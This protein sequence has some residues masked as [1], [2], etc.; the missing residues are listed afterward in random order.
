[1]TE[2]VID[3]KKNVL[4]LEK[5]YKSLQKKAALKSK[6]EQMLFI[7]EARAYSMKLIKKWAEEQN[8]NPIS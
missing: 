4:L 6:S 3:K 8:T 1:M 7:E 2:I 5:D